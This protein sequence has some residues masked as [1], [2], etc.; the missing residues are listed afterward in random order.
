MGLAARA[1]AAG[2]EGRRAVNNKRTNGQMAGAVLFGGG[3]PGHCGKKLSRHESICAEPV[4]C[5]CLPQQRRL[6]PVGRGRHQRVA[7]HVLYLPR[8][9][10][11]PP[12]EHRDTTQRPGAQPETLFTDSLPGSS[13][14]VH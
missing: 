3:I 2:R 10:V 13:R 8:A 12:P 7:L 4:L 1:R 6:E 11:V 14:V 9:L 5:L